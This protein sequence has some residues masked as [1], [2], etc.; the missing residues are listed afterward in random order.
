MSFLAVSKAVKRSFRLPD[1]SPNLLAR[2]ENDV[3]FS[4]SR[5]SGGIPPASRARYPVNS[6]QF[7]DPS[8]LNDTNTCRCN[9]SHNPL[10]NA[11]ALSATMCKYSYVWQIDDSG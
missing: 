6:R 4:P 10:L 1:G 7:Q 11:C 9:L 2:G 3:L 8:A 5:P